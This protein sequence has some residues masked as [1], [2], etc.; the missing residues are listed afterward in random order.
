M[1]IREFDRRALERTCVI[2]AGIT[3]EHLELPTPCA[4]WTLRDLLE[5]MVG[6]HDGFAAAARA[7]A[8]AVDR[9]LFAPRPVSGD[10][11]RIHADSVA[12]VIAAFADC[13]G[14]DRSFWLPEFRATAPF[15][16]PTAI[17]FHF[18]DAVVHGWDVARTLDVAPGFDDDLVE[19]V[20]PIAGQVPDDPAARLAGGFF[21]P[22]LPAPTTE[23]TLDRI[24]AMLGRDPQWTAV[25]A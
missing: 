11:A 6:Q 16:A 4:G 7:G 5:H 14:A 9:E 15:P 19:A 8:D 2:L 1:D 17:G 18:L 12:A 13:G 21:A 23:S 24:L 10:P 25:H 22:S 20:L 3:D